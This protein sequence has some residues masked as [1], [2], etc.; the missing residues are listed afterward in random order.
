MDLVS[1]ILEG[2]RRAAARLM[3]LAEDGNPKATDCLARLHPHTGNAHIIG[4]TGPPGSGKSTLV[5]KLTLEYR[6]RG[7]TVGI[8]AVDPTSPFTGGALLGD[9]IR[10]NEVAL[11]KH[12]F[13]RSMGTRGHLGGLAVK[14]GEL[15]KILD[16]LGK[17]VILVETVGAGQSEVE[18]VDTAH[19]TVIVEVPGLGDD[20]Q[21]IK[22][23]ILEIGDVFVVNKADLDGAN[24]T[25]RELDAMLDMNPENSHWRPP[26]LQTI[27]K[28]GEGVTQVVDALDRHIEYLRET[29]SLYKMIRV[30]TESELR[31]IIGD[32]ILRFVESS[33]EENKLDELVD[34]IVEGELDP[35]SAAQ[36]YLE[37]LF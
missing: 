24:E 9:R 27:C 1:R 15:V 19:S 5:D 31:D 8:V 4:I 34:R 35:Y 30:R 14:T 12:V 36:R 22:A 17:E 25:A 20:I 37:L 28:D 3:T 7:K 23:G 16:A 13:I 18:I 6:R 32:R 29:G 26:I 21:A 11:D 10:M 33:A 2:D